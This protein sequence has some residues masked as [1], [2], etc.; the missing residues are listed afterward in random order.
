MFVQRVRKPLN[1]QKMSCV[2]VQKNDQRVRKLLRGLELNFR[3]E[4]R[5]GRWNRNQGGDLKRRE[6]GT[7]ISRDMVACGMGVCQYLFLTVLRSNGVM[8]RSDWSGC[9]RWWVKAKTRVDSNEKQ[10]E[11]PAEFFGAADVCV[12][13][14]VKAQ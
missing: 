9:F 12:T 3:G 5:M 4:E 11:L 6:A 8:R 14:F 1:S 2:F 7:R 13:M 10:R